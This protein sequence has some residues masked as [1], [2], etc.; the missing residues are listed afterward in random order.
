MIRGTSEHPI[1][2]LIA[3]VA[4]ILV[5]CA[6]SQ[7]YRTKGLQACAH[8]KACTD[9]TIEQHEHPDETYDLAFVEFTDRGNIF[10]RDQMEM[11][12]EHVR[13]LAQ[14]KENASYEGVL[15]VVFVHGWKHNAS[16]NDSNVNDFR[17]LLRKTARLDA[18]G[19]RKL[20]GVYVGWRGASI[21]LPWIEEITYWDRKGVAEQVGKGGVTEL[22]TR[23]ERIV[24]DGK[25]PNRNL[26]LVVGH[27]F[28]GAIVLSG[29]NEVLLERV[30]AADPTPDPSGEQCF[31]SK[32]FGHGVVLLN[33]AMEANEAFQLKEVV[34]RMCF[35]A[36]QA[37]LMHVITS[38]ADDATGSL[39]GL[40]QWFAMLR[41]KEAD[42]ARSDNFAVHES[43]IDTTTVGHYLP[44]QTGQLCSRE[45]DRPEC[46][47]NGRPDDC[48]R[49]SPD[50]G[51]IYIS[52]A[53]REDCVGADD[54]RH[55]EV[56]HNEPLAFIQ[57][58][59][60]FIGDH[61]DVFTNGVAAYLA[62]ILVEARHKRG[63]TTESMLR[64]PPDALPACA[65]KPY[66]FGKCLH[67]Y[68]EA[69]ATIS[70]DQP[71]E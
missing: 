26:F 3:L 56:G 68:E 66:D 67:A 52:Y 7:P 33:A 69:F 38:D 48:F 65:A 20:V 47:R 55:I 57:T 64:H 59:R 28:G 19:R 29:L 46:Q 14:P 31:K 45:S 1:P 30:V 4:L 18:G 23:L 2:C 34:S 32:P 50:G 44:F 27:S 35:P 24:I 41:W 53:G 9:A 54:Q 71:N 10:D 16:P 13:E 62:A 11:V 63:E 5:G 51:R 22:L 21:T 6:E 40:G 37:R 43:V 8:A 25:E 39:F 60:G 58:D 61:N 15:V 17:E 12:L 42:L 70:L 36:N 49:V